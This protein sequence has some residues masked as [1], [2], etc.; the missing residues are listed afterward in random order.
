MRIGTCLALCLSYEC[1]TIHKAACCMSKQ[2][3]RHWPTLY[4]ATAQDATLSGLPNQRTFIAANLKEVGELM[5]HYVLQLLIAVSLM[6]EGKAYV[7]IHE[8]GSHDS[9][10]I[11]IC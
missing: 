4:P 6:P 3:E 10:G 9:T 8:S 1:D 11:G 2:C 5:P 7:S